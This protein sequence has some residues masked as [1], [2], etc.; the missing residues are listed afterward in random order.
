METMNRAE[1]VA[2]IRELIKEI[3][4]CMLTT[5]DD[6]DGRLHSRPMA[7]SNPGEFDGD[8]WFFTYGRSHKGYDVGQ[9]RQVNCAFAHP[10]RQSYVSASGKASIVR[11]RDEIRRRW[12]AVYAAWFPSGVDEPDLALLRVDVETA[13]YWDSPSSVVAHAIA[14]V[15]TQVLG[16]RPDLGENKVVNLH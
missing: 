16:Q 9:N 12:K 15:K 13:E 5:V 4:I 8:L 7:V 10:G 2:K 6:I 3:E 11:D 1:G 14:L